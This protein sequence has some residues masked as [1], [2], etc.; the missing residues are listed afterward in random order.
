MWEENK[1]E[2]VWKA[3]R[4]TDICLQRGFSKL[5]DDKRHRSKL[6]CDRLKWIVKDRVIIVTERVHIA[7]VGNSVCERRN[8]L[9]AEKNFQDE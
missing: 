5:E 3:C 1:C 2:Y 7:S 4:N 9:G 8:F 6:T